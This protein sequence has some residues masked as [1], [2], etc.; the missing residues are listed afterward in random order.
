MIYYKVMDELIYRVFSFTLCSGGGIDRVSP[1]LGG[2][3]GKGRGE[4]GGI[5]D[6]LVARSREGRNGG[7][8]SAD[9]ERGRNAE[10]GEKR[11]RAQLN[12]LLRW[13]DPSTARNNRMGW[14]RVISWKYSVIPVPFLS[15]AIKSAERI[16]FVPVKRMTL[17]RSL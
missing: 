16:S 13:R 4:G 6:R 5:L 12:R 9:S 3:G 17:Q 2:E 10:E 1:L 8:K 11:R 15:R 14:R 7:R